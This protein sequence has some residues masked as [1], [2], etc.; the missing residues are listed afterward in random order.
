M[1]TTRSK[2][3]S[4]LSITAAVMV[5]VYFALLIREIGEFCRMGEYDENH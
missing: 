3:M 2:A 4:K 5:A 1:H